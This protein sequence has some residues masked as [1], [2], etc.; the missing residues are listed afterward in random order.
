MEAGDAEGWGAGLGGHGDSLVPALQPHL[1]QKHHGGFD[2]LA[3]FLQL[4]VVVLLL[5][6][7]QLGPLC[8]RLG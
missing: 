2:D 3:P 7:Q 5:G 1:V 4:G 6:L 8:L